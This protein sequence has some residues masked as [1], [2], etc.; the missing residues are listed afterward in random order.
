MLNYQGTCIH[1]HHKA[2]VCDK[3]IFVKKVLQ[4]NVIISKIKIFFKNFPDQTHVYYNKCTK[5]CYK[6]I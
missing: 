2:F 3:S 6:D 4:F 1:Q 5:I